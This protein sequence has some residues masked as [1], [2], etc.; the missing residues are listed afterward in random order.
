[1][2]E[3]WYKCVDSYHPW[4]VGTIESLH[5]EKDRQ[6]NIDSAAG[7]LRTPG[8]LAAAVVSVALA[9]LA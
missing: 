4:P 8:A 5:T 1:M 3:E 7:G 2:T 9:A 6:E